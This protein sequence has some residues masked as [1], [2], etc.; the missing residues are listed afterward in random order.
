MA[1]TLC[2]EGCGGHCPPHL[3]FRGTRTETWLGRRGSPPAAL[4]NTGHTHTLIHTHTLTHAQGIMAHHLTAPSRSLQRGDERGRRRGARI[5][6]GTLGKPNTK[7]AI[8][9]AKGLQL[10]VSP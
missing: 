3:D 4:E 2:P 10:C 1:R 5:L 6:R 8:V 9:T 7:L